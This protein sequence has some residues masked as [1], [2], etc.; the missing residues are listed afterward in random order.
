[1]T[2]ALIFVMKQASTEE[3]FKWHTIYFTHETFRGV[4]MNVITTDQVHVLALADHMQKLIVAPDRSL[5]EFILA[6]KP[7]IDYYPIINVGYV[8]TRATVI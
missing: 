6:V 3:S 4:A 1:M 8:I 5:H 7:P 2:L